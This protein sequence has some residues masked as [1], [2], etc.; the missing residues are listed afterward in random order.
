MKRWIGRWIIAIGVI[1]NLV[2]LY[3]FA[4]VLREI[5]AAGVWN[6]VG[7]DTMR[8]LAFWFLYTGCLL[9]VVG[10]L[11]DWIEERTGGALP[12]AYGW[13]LLALLL[14]GV[15]LIPESGFWLLVPAI[16]SSMR[17]MRSGA[18]AAAGLRAQA[19]GS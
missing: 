17:R 13:M 4:P 2:G 18:R 1:H 10:Y 12:N 3:F 5:G 9:M 14:L 7:V 11:T 6:A 8:N 15:V 19:V 16:A